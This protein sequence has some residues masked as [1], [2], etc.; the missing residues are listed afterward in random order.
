MKLLNYKLNNKFC[1]ITGAAGLLGYEHA[2]AILEAEGNVVLTDLNEKKLVQTQKKLKNIFSKQKVLYYK[3][4]VSNIDS[5][6]F[7]LKKLKKKK[8]K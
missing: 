4:D 8:S 5:I 7:V 1:L 3:M 6:N 2:S